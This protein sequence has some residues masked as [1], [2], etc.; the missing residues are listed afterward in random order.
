LTAT[1]ERPAVGHGFHRPSVFR[2]VVA[3]TLAISVVAMAGSPPAWLSVTVVLGVVAVLGIP[4]GS[5]DHVV[6]AELAGE[7]FS[8][9]RFAVRYVAAMAVVGL[10]WLAS[11]AVA[12][13]LFLAASIHHFGQSDLAHLRLGGARQVAVQWSRGLLLVGLPLLAHLDDVAPVVDRLGV[14]DP[15]AWTG[16]ADTWWLWC[17]VIVVQ[18]AAVLGW[19]A[20]AVPDR[21]LGREVVTVAVLVPLFLVSD[22]LVG[23]AVYFGLW[24]SVSHLLVL[25]DTIG[26]GPSPMRSIAR[27]AVPLTSV[28]LGG[29]ALA[30]G[31]AVV[32]GRPELVVPAVFVFVSML[33]V[34]HLLVVERLWRARVAA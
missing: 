14:G 33:T 1:L 27:R 21:T 10:V 15:T 23:F 29:L 31:A 3:A 26:S 13:T 19:V 5:L 4:H 17:A 9:R 30:T 22:P 28:S 18:H 32:G 6:A 12:L 8:L 34:P 20:A 2:P 24:H 25:G 16:L 11:P 7:R